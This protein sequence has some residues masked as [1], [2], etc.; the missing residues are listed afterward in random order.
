MAATEAPTSH[1][2]RGADGRKAR[3]A[4]S[5]LPSH[6]SGGGCTGG[7][8]NAGGHRSHSSGQRQET[9]QAPST[10]L[11]LDAGS[12]TL[13]ETVVDEKASDLSEEAMQQASAVLEHPSTGCRE[14]EAVLTKLS[15]W[16]EAPSASKA[17]ALL[18]SSGMPTAVV[19]AM[20]K[21]RNSPPVAALACMHMVRAS[22]GSAEN[23]AAHVR[24]GAIEEITE[25]MDQHSSHGGIQNVCLLLL[26]ELIKDGAVARQALAHGAVSRVLRALE[27]T[28]GREVQYNG[29]LALR[30]LLDSGRATRTMQEDSGRAARAGMQAAAMR[31]KEEHPRD[32]VLC[33]QANDVLALVTPRFKEVLCWHWQNGWCRLGPRCTY[34]HGPEELRST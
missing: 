21:F 25:L 29:C 23:A 5:A 10:P 18:L 34:A 24:A 17:L 22:R 15:L 2:R 28:S 13:A 26:S 8:A 16:L 4:G 9:G 12:T 6:S 11:Q 1:R 30:L 14:A 32:E 19:H 20:R 3:G 7:A 33:A 31:A 27:S